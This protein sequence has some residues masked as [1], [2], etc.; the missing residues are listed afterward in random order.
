MEEKRIFPPGDLLSAT[1][2]KLPR[3]RKS[4]RTRPLIPY[5]NDLTNQN[6][7]VGLIAL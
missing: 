6:A 4:L 5:L 7:M 3:T 1:S 2:H